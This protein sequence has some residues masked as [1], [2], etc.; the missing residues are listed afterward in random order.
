MLSILKH[1]LDG[2]GRKNNAVKAQAKFVRCV[3]DLPRMLGTM[4]TCAQGGWR[5]YDGLDVFRKREH[6]CE[7]LRVSVRLFLQIVM[8][9]RL[10]RHYRW[11]KNVDVNK[12]L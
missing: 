6:I 3:L 1:D 4:Y 11:L 7:G 8:D 12:P 10:T 5:H 2:A 9:L